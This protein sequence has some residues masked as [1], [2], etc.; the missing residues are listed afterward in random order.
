M[1]NLLEI[2]YPI[3]PY[4]ITQVWGNP[5]DAYSTQFNDPNFTLHNGIDANVE[6]SGNIEYQTQF[7]IYCPVENFRVESVS[8][9]ANGGGNQISLVSLDPVVMG[10]KTCFARLFL[11]HGK[12]ILVKEGC[13]PKLGELL[14]IGN[15]TG[16]STG[17]HT[18]LGLYRIDAQGNKLDQNHATGSCNP[19]SFF[20][21]TYA[22]DEANLATLIGNGMTLAKYYMGIS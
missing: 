11:C 4:V 20:T 6:R 19:A 10:D 12:K 21:N 22:I 15:N 9:E 8:F 13:M 16:F 7:P 14:M 1:A 3:K 17:P 2:R 5:S 18:H